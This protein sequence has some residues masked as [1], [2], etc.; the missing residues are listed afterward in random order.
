[1]LTVY[2]CARQGTQVLCDADLTNQNT[3]ETLMQSADA[4]KDAFI[5]DDR[6]DR[7]PRTNGF[8][9]NIDGEQRQ[10]LDVSYGKSARFILAFDG[11]SDKVANV[12]LRSTASGLHV[13][14]IPL[15]APADA[16][17]PAQ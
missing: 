8:F 4:W 9:L 10:Q 5:V 14:N 6:G 2:R 3:Q 1:M 13:E 15:S 7:H 16:A 17:T 11:V 12:A